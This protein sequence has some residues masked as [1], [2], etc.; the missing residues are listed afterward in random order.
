MVG[1][2]VRPLRRCWPDIKVLV[3]GLPNQEDA[4]LHSLAAHIDGIV[5]AEESLEQLAAAIRDVRAN[6]FRSPPQLIRP[7]FNRLVRLPPPPNAA[8]WKPSINRLSTRELQVLAFIE[9]GESNKAIA[10][11]LF[12]EEHTV[13]N[14]VTQILRKLG[15]RTRYD[16][17]RIAADVRVQRCGGES[18]DSTRARSGLM[19]SRSPI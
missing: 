1:R 12:I 5:L 2:A 18:R 9:R 3:V 13:K 7:L 4:I 15:V 17:A 8:P 16:A 14:H 10:A 6:T 11:Q 19:G